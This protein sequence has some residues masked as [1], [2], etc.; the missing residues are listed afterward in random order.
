MALEIFF[1]AFFL[2]DLNPNPKQRRIHVKTMEPRI[3]IFGAKNFKKKNSRSLKLH[4]EKILKVRK[5]FLQ[6]K[7]IHGKILETEGKNSHSQKFSRKIPAAKIL[8]KKNSGVE[9][10]IGKNFFS[11]KSL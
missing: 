7:I 2:S 11:R 10:P 8:T 9:N 1:F 4:Q 3:K 5:K 6:S